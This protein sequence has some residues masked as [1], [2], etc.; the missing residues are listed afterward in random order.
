VDARGQT[1]VLARTI[2]N[3]FEVGI[4]AYNEDGKAATLYVDDV[5]ISVQPMRE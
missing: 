4:S 3:S 5:S 1:L 2:F